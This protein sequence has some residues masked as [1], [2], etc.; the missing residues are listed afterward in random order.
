MLFHYS[1]ALLSKFGRFHYDIICKN[2]FIQ[3]FVNQ[4]F[5]HLCFSVF[6]DRVSYEVRSLS[7]SRTLKCLH[8]DWEGTD[9]YAQGA[10]WGYRLC[11]IQI[12]MICAQHS[13]WYLVGICRMSP[14][15]L[16][17]LIRKKKSCIKILECLLF[18]RFL[19]TLWSLLKPQNFL[20][21]LFRISMYEST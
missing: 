9:A 11:F 13:T 15:G 4:K 2:W 17:L 7:H 16:Y 8:R 5:V 18:A 1:S 6:P 3:H 12:C 21:S 20:Q 10:P 14:C 19:K